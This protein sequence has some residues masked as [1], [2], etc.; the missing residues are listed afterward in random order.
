MQLGSAYEARLAGWRNRRDHMLAAAERFTARTGDGGSTLLQ[1]LRRI[2]ESKELDR[3]AWRRVVDLYRGADRPTRG[4]VFGLQL[5][6]EV[7]LLH[8]QPALAWD[9]I[10][11]A[12]TLGLMD[13]VWLD[14]CPLFDE[15]RGNPDMIAVRARVA[16]RAERVRA[17]L[18]SS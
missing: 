17:A 15:H 5:L 1:F 18:K 12:E 7:A 16:E 4:T 14:R 9:T 2:A 8:A 11:A 3:D 6:A 13:I 10:A